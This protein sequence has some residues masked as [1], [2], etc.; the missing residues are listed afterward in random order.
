MWRRLLSVKGGCAAGR[1]IG[2]FGCGAC[3][4]DQQTSLRGRLSLRR[5][6]MV[7]AACLCV[8]RSPDQRAWQ[9]QA[10]GVERG[11]GRVLEGHSPQQAYALAVCE[12]LL[13]SGS[14]DKSIKVW[15]MGEAATW[16]CE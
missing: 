1:W 4:L 10:E 2:L 5:Q 16:T 13:M 15:A 9:W 12:S 11:D 14:R 3:W 6:T 7:C 8:A